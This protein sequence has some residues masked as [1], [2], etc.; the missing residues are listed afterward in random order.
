MAL[1]VPGPEDKP[2]LYLL[3]AGAPTKTLWGG[4]TVQGVPCPHMERCMA[5]KA[6]GRAQNVVAL[7]GRA[8]HNA[9]LLFFCSF[10]PG[11]HEPLAEV[12]G[13]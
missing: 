6:G 3:Q 12:F 1:I 13:T 4:Y 7:G 5:E 10:I 9:M 8:R 2:T 11:R